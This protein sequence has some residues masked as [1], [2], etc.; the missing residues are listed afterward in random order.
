MLCLLLGIAALPWCS[1][2]GDLGTAPADGGPDGDADADRGGDE[3]GVDGREAEDSPVPEDSVAED[4]PLPCSTPLAE[5]V[6]VTE[7]SVAPGSVSVSSGEYFTPGRPVIL[8]ALPGGGAK[9]AW[10]DETPL[11]H[12]TPLDAAGARAGPDATLAGEEVR[13]FVAHDDGAAVLV[14]RGDV[15]ALVRI[16]DAGDVVFDLALVGG[17][18]HGTDGARWIDE[19]SHEGRL[20][21]SGSEY[22][23]YFGQTGNWGAGGNHQGDRLDT[24]T[25]SG[26][27]SYGGWDWGCSHSLDVRLAHNGATFGP[28]CL[29]DCYPGKGI[30]Y[31]RT[32]LVREEPSGNCAGSSSATL[33]GLAPVSGGFWLAFTSGEGR[34][35]QD[36][37]LVRIGGSGAV[38]APVFLTDTAG[39][40]ETSAHLAPYGSGLLAGWSRGGVN[41]L[42]ALDASGA[43]VE[44]PADASVQWAERDDFTDLA[45][46]D[47]GWAWAWGDMT[48]LKIVRVARCE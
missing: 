34:S 9:V 6:T 30:C 48:R 33:G 11:V 3:G 16:D 24:V 8:S 44:G 28:V 25:S 1:C 32:T 39:A 14:R 47:V 40:N 7:V 15:M 21:W 13:G 22:A 35:S 42:A 27:L 26:T 41:V 12:V 5:R 23:A 43:I 37:G 38:G 45:D 29:S 10:T 20:A 31:Q 36:V 2:G 4:A 19:W 18:S 17:S 46:G